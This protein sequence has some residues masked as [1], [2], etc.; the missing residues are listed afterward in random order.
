M[1]RELWLKGSHRG[2]SV[3]GT[4]VDGTHR[5]ALCSPPP[6]A[7][8]DRGAGVKRDARHP[9]FLLFPPV[10]TAVFSLASADGTFAHSS[11]SWRL[12]VEAAQSPAEGRAGGGESHRGGRWGAGTA[13]ALRRLTAVEAFTEVTVDW[14]GR[15]SEGQTTTA[16]GKVCVGSWKE[17]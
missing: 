15:K 1:G 4:A 6:V 17:V 16:R 2:W 12:R 13:F 9:H 3:A 5:V 7:G 10:R 8:G 11:L 14:V